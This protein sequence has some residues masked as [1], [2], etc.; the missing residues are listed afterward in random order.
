MN[1]TIARVA[2][3]LL[4]D[5]TSVYY[6]DLR[7]DHYECYSTNQGYQK[8]E[9]QSS[10]EDFFNESLRNIERVIYPDDIEPIRR[11]LHKPTM[12]QMLQGKHMITHTYRLMVGEG[13]YREMPIFGAL[14]I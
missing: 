14:R 11:L 12:V 1:T 9:L 3:A 10:G 8:L 4:I 7:T 5:Y 2:M 6:I 13:I